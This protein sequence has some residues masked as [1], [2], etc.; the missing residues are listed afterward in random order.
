MFVYHVYSWFV[1]RYYLYLKLLLWWF[2]LDRLL[3]FVKVTCVYLL[4]HHV[5]WNTYAWGISA[6]HLNS[7]P[8]FGNN[9]P[10]FEDWLLK[11]CQLFL[12]WRLSQFGCIFCYSWSKLFDGAYY[13]HISHPSFCYCSHTYSSSFSLR[14][15]NIQTWKHVWM[16]VHSCENIS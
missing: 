3:K 2:S 13:I 8:G 15:V 11:L 14:G 5:C 16:F 6:V 1:C 12:F 9:L 10:Q 7:L 4:T